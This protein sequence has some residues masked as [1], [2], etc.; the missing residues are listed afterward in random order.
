MCVCV[1]C[2]TMVCCVVLCCYGRCPRQPA[3]PP[4]PWRRLHG[5]CAYMDISI[6]GYMDMYVCVC[7]CMHWMYVSLSVY[8]TYTCILYI[9]M[10]VH[11]LITACMHVW[12][13][14]IYMCRAL[15]Q[16][17]AIIADNAGLDASDLV[18]KLRAEHN[19]GEPADI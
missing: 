18:T 2:N 13:I 11:M 9:H 16:L 17:P 19:A 10:Y 4:W 5:E 3:R 15:R 8:I 7:V 14:C 1:F 6:Y 12:H